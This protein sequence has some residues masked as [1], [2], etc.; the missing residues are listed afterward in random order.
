VDLVVPELVA[1][2]RSNFARVADQQVGDLV[3]AAEAAV[4][5]ASAIEHQI[6]AMARHLALDAGVPEQALGVVA[7]PAPLKM[8]AAEKAE[9][10]A[11]EGLEFFKEL[12]AVGAPSGDDDPPKTA[13]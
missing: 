11:S 2:A 10:I 12:V 13:A 5:E 6:G 9:V 4:D 8:T 3:E 1:A 7:R